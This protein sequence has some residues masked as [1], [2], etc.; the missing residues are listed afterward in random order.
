M[1][2]RIL[3]LGLGFSA[4]GGYRV[5]SE[6][7]NAWIRQGHDCAFLVPATSSE[8]YFSTNARILRSDWSGRM[9][10][11]FANRKPSGIDS[12]LSLWAGLRKVGK[13]Y[14]VILADHSLAAWP[15]YL[16]NCGIA[17][18]IYYLQAY[19]PEYIPVCKRPIKHFLAKASYR[20]DLIQITNSSTYQGAG[21]SP[22]AIIPPGI[23][24]SVFTLK[25]LDLDFDRKPT[26]TFGTIGRLEPYK[27]TATAIS[28]YRLLRQSDSRLRLR[29]A[30]GNVNPEDDL[31]IIPLQG[32][33]QLAAF[34]RSVDV[35]IVSCFGQWGAPH[36]P[37]IE[38]M[39]SGTP[40]VHTGYYPGTPENSWQAAD[41]STSGIAKSLRDLLE[42]SIEERS[43]RVKLA[44]E[45][46]EQSLGW[47]VAALQFSC[48]FS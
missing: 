2:K 38:A 14:D 20:L 26:I 23:D 22:V 3:I 33:A 7:A 27:G 24:L 28:A 4:T 39:A 15:L 32:D 37:L 25:E 42:S 35:L 31:E 36:Y 19:E 17:K 10:S 48:H 21:L 29:V 12:I 13:N 11:P 30:Y 6:L 1:T 44:R 40:V 46:I 9:T 5:L 43:C 16:S 18:K 45:T 41:S 34:Y 8:P 47:D